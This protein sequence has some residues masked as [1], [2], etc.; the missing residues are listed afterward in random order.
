[1]K[2]IEPVQI[3]YNGQ[4]KSATVLNSYASNVQLNQNANF[5]YILMDIDEFGQINNILSQGSL[6]MPTEEYL[7]WDQ[8]EFAW[9]F[10]AK[11]L[12]I[13]ITGDYIK[14]KNP[15]IETPIEKLEEKA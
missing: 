15:I 12:N 1:M 8:D 5:C 2:T 3:W 11:S 6:F 7:Q 14:P 9:D 10:I 4:I 13:V